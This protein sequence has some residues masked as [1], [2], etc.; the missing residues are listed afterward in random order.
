MTKQ[1][2]V[3]I[4]TGAARG[5]GFSIAEAF[6]QNG[7]QPIIADLSYEETQKAAVILDEKYRCSAE[8]YTVDVA[9]AQSVEML[10]NR[11]TDKFGRV[12]V[13]VNNAGL[14]HVD[15]IE[16]FPVDKWDQ[17]IGVMLKGPFLMT[18]YVIPHMK[19]QQYGRIINIASVH[20]KLASPYKSAYVSAKHGV[21]GLTRTAALELADH[22]ITVNAVL[23]GVVHTKLID[24]QLQRLADED[25]TSPEEAL[26]KHLLAKQAV[27][28]F[29][30]PEEVA[31]CCVFLASDGAASITGD[32]ISV[33]GGW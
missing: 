9:D 1:Q 19:K 5:I 22:N 12:D 24:D 31:A 11:V 17:L 28:R 2:R 16:H 8:A 33:S 20:G 6:A 32:S 30:K 18:K 21:V 10:I 27:K 29:V 23:P 13:V 3:V 14:Q 15:P 7:D 26:Q 4:I 25:G